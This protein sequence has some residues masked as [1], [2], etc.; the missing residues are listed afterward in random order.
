M[1]N[2]S[3]GNFRL[4]HMA[5]ELPIWEIG[6]VSVMIGALYLYFSTLPELVERGGSRQ[7]AFALASSFVL[8][9]L[10]EISGLLLLRSRAKLFPRR[11]NHSTVVALA[12]YLPKDEIVNL[13]REAQELGRGSSD[14][15]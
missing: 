13:M 7:G 2:E 8:V 4:G 15:E 10:I 14:G 11:W 5:A 6:I 12:P 9:L 3:H 1:T